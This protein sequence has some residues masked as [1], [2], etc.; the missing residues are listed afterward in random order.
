MKFMDWIYPADIITGLQ[1]FNPLLTFSI[2]AA[3]WLIAGLIV[4]FVL[5]RKK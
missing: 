2:F 3:L 5:K 4:F 1:D